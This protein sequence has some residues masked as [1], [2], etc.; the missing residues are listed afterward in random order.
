M[1]VMG[2]D[3]GASLRIGDARRLVEAVLSHLPDGRLAL[4]LH[5]ENGDVVASVELREDFLHAWAR[6]RAAAA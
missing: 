1:N 2:I 5:D 4:N 6:A 3:P